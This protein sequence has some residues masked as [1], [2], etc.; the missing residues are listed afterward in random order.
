LAVAEE[1]AEILEPFDD[2]ARTRILA[3]VDIM[4]A[5]TIVDNSE[6]TTPPTEDDE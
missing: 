2:N 4:L 3:H 5:D 1:I 6:P